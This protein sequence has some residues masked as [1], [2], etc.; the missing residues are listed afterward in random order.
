MSALKVKVEHSFTNVVDA[1]K[2]ELEVQLKQ[3]AGADD[4]QEVRDNKADVD[5]V[6]ALRMHLGKLNKRMRFLEEEHERA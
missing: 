4:V 1:A 3:K 2:L 6:E 5:Q